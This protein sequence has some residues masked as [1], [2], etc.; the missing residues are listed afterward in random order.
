M[1]R[2]Y[3]VTARFSDPHIDSDG[4]TRI[5]YTRTW[6]YQDKR[7]AK[8]RVRTC[9]EGL[10][11]QPGLGPNGD[12]G[13]MP[14]QPKAEWVRIDRSDPITWPDDAPRPTVLTA[15]AGGPS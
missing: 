10:P 2:L 7:A 9:R 1:K 5:G 12:D 6:H 8:R 3:R 13:F 14:G 15:I 11:E 4:V